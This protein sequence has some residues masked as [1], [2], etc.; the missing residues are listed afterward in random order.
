LF[1]LPS[2]RKKEPLIKTPICFK[3]DVEWYREG[4]DYT[5]Q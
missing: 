1:P 5:S 3:I 4:S 2:N